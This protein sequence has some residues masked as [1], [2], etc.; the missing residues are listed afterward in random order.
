MPLTKVDYSKTII[1]KIQH[2]DN[3]ELL[4]VGSTTDFTRR[5]AQHKRDCYNANSKCYNYKL[6]SIIRDNGGFDCFNII[7]IKEFP[8]NNNQEALIEEDK[9]MRQM[10]CNMNERRAF[11]TPEEKIEND[12][13]KYERDRERIL[14]RQKQYNELHKEQI[15]Q[16]Y[17]QNKP[18]RLEQ[19]KRNYEQNKPKR[20]EQRKQNYEQNKPKRLEQQKYY[21]E[22][23]RE[24]IAERNKIK[25]TCECGCVITKYYLLNHRRTKKHQDLLNMTEQ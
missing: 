15:K 3:D 8:C 16:N 21:N 7:V 2:R 4:Y 1:Y 14:E 19:S 20:L 6:Y 25:M 13:Q 18:K 17:E 24:Q 23:H 10:K 12:R 22:I 11:T 5:K 9:I